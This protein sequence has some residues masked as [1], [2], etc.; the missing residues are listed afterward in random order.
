MVN[1]AAR[2]LHYPP[3]YLDTFPSQQWW[4]RGHEPDKGVSILAPMAQIRPL[5][6]RTRWQWLTHPQ[7]TLVAW[8]VEDGPL[9]RGHL[10][11]PCSWHVLEGGYRT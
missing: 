6:A 9:P 10:R 8:S 5:Q 3:N 4:G 11:A 1:V 2:R 7:V